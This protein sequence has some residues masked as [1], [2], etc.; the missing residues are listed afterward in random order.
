MI[1]NLYLVTVFALLFA[2]T[3]FTPVPNESL[4]K[5]VSVAELEKALKQSTNQ[6]V[7]YNFWAT[8]C[9]PCKE[10][11]PY[12]EALQKAYPD[13]TLK[14]ILLSLDFPSGR[15]YLPDFVK[16]KGMEAEVWYLHDWMEGNDW[17]GRINKK[18]SGAIPATI[19]NMPSKGI[20]DFKE[21][22]LTKEELN[23]WV[24]GTMEKAGL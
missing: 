24:A 22:E 1:R 2:L 6:L 9:G 19:L 23:S 16:E 21:G 12:F 8:W 3:A 17:I 15:K 14:V 13:K 7:V 10:E 4:I 18:W 20:K 5:D 11:L